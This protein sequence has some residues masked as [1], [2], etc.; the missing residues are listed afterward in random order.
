MSV[1][2]NRKMEEMIPN[3][4]VECRKWGKDQR[5]LVI[6]CARKRLFEAGFRIFNFQLCN[7]FYI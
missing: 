2:R 1:H 4:L 6:E 7:Q 3:S 5:F